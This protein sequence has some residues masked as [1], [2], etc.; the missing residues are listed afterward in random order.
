MF[1]V[2]KRDF[3]EKNATKFV[4]GQLFSFRNI[5]LA[6]S[7]VIFGSTR[8]DFEHK[9]TVK[10]SMP[11]NPQFITW[12]A[13]CAHRYNIQSGRQYLAY[14]LHKTDTATVKWCVLRWLRKKTKLHDLAGRTHLIGVILLAATRVCVVWIHY[15]QNVNK[16]ER[17]QNEKYK[18]YS[19]G[20]VAHTVQRSDRR[21][22]KC[23]VSRS[24]FLSLIKYAMATARVCFFISCL[25]VRHSFLAVLS[26]AFCVRTVE[27]E[28]IHTH[29]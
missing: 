13:M 11:A 15:S 9:Q 28:P 8:I 23:I 7:L 20:D 2:R 24:L 10:R 1:I 26:H 21:L 5:G 16:M 25:F 3:A 19:P 22:H 17:K 14:S 29:D 6:V 18:L 27:Y 12:N 4:F